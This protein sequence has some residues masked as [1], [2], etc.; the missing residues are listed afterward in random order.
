MNCEKTSMLTYLKEL[1][2]ALDQTSL[3]LNNHKL[4]DK[5]LIFYNTLV[6]KYE[7]LENSYES[8]YGPINIKIKNKSS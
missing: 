7:S 5:A 6:K 8:K 1:D 4:D 3:Y 2:F